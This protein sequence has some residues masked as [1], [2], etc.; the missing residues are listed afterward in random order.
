M[1]AEIVR[2]HIENDVRN[3]APTIVFTDSSGQEWVHDELTAE[4][5]F[6]TKLVKKEDS[7]Y[8]KPK[9]PKP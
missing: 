2:T 1:K 5:G 8:F 3:N 9:A 6:I 4:H 7:W